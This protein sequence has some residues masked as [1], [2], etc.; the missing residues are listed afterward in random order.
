[1]SR[2]LRSVSTESTDAVPHPKSYE[3]D[4]LMVSHPEVENVKAILGGGQMNHT[5]DYQRVEQPDSESGVNSNSSADFPTPAQAKEVA[6]G[7]AGALQEGS[8][9]AAVNSA[10]AYEVTGSKENWID[11]NPPSVILQQHRSDEM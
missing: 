3:E 2:M 11:R 9:D 1:M 4:I 10:L 7:L 5:P 8:M 6:P